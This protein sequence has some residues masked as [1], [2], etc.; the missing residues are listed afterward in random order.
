[1]VQKRFRRLLYL[2][3]LDIALFGATNATTAPSFVVMV[4]FVCLAVTSYYLIYGL[5]GLSGFYGL[6]ITRKRTLALYLTIVTGGLLALQSI[7]E[8]GSR[9]V[10]V[11]LPLAVVGYLYSAYAKTS[12]RNL[13]S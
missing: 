12:R 13:G 8:L 5:I 6:N 3:T 4:G 9:D 1:M 10:L 11:V 2:L 7:G